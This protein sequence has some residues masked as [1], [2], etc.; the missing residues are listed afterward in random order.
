MRYVVAILGFML[1]IYGCESGKSV[2]KG[3]S[4]TTAKSMDTIRIANDSL[5]Y[6]II[7]MDIGFNNWLVTQPPQGYYSQTFLENKN[8]VFVTEYN[9]RV[10]NFQLYD[11]NLYQQE[12][13]YDFKIDYGYE[14]NYLLYNYMMF[15]QQRYNQSF[16]GGR[17][18]RR[19]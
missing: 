2:M 11:R 3:D 8:M 14:V 18:G 7:I 5:E 19:Q 13:N 15:F 9:R 1:M 10:Q 6:E 12:I 17:R 16:I 4:G